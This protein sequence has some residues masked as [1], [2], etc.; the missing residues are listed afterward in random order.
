MILLVCIVLIIGFFD[1]RTM[2]KN[3][4]QSDIICFVIISVGSILYGYYY[5]THIYT[6]S[7]IDFI[8]SLLQVQ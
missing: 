6:A 5:N 7:L 1:F 2:I 3:K 4:H 8:I